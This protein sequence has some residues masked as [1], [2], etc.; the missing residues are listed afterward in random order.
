MRHTHFT[1]SKVKATGLT[2]IADITV[3]RLVDNTTGQQL[4]YY[5]DSHIVTCMSDR[6]Q[7]AILRLPDAVDYANSLLEA[8]KV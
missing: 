5:P 2:T 7:N 4:G 8:V 3:R 1:T 6:S